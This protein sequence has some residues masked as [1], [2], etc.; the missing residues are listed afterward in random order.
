MWTQL[1]C[2]CSWKHVADISTDNKA[3]SVKPHTE[4]LAERPAELHQEAHYYRRRGWGGW[5]VVSPSHER[6][7]HSFTTSI[8]FSVWVTHQT[9]TTARAVQQ[10]FQLQYRQSRQNRKPHLMYKITKCLLIYSPRSSIYKQV[11]WSIKLSNDFFSLIT[12]IWHVSL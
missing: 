6:S 11:I 4:T 12:V 9:Q 2:E 7:W 10:G 3:Q 8:V 5:R 1:K